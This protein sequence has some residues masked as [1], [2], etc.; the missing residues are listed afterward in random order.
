MI[1]ILHADQKDENNPFNI[2]VGVC[3]APLFAY[4]K[5][6][7]EKLSNRSNQIIIDMDGNRHNV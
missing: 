1:I 2:E 6:I 7:T 5:I 4:R 3:C